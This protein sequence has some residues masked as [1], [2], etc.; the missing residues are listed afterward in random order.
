MPKVQ[1]ESVAPVRKARGVRGR[2]HR[3]A[4]G[5]LE[6]SR[7]GRVFQGIESIADGSG[8]HRSR[9]EDHARLLARS[10]AGGGAG[11]ELRAARE[12]RAN[13]S[14]GGECEGHSG[15]CG[16]C[17]WGCAVR[18]TTTSAIVP[19]TMIQRHAQVFKFRP[20]VLHKIAF[21]FMDM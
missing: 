7:R 18:V 1:S 21:I 19:A 8:I 2:V 12:L 11:V 15:A 20:P 5:V 14:R 9:R 13:G 6:C 17:R 10:L 16:M 4:C 3:V